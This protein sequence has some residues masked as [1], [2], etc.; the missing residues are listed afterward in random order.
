MKTKWFNKRAKLYSF[1]N[2]AFFEEESV[3]DRAVVGY[4]NIWKYKFRF[5]LYI[6]KVEKCQHMKSFKNNLV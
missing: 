3:M 4:L 1:V 6:E 5:K 2:Y